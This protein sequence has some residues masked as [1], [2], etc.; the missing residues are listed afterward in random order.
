MAE[1]RMAEAGGGGGSDGGG[2]CQQGKRADV[3]IWIREEAMTHWIWIG[4]EA[5]VRWIREE[6]FRVL[7][8]G[9]GWERRGRRR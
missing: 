2:T 8:E 7:W 9:S 6:A 4:E 3:S 1:G 5:A